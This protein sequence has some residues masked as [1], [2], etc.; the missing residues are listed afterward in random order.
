MALLP[1]P[2]LN[3]NLLQG[4]LGPSQANSG[5]FQGTNQINVNIFTAGTG[6]TPDFSVPPPPLPLQL[7]SW[8]TNSFLQQGF[9]LP[10]QAVQQTR[11]GEVGNFAADQKG[12]ESLL[13]KGFDLRIQFDID[14]NPVRQTWLLKY[15]DFQAS[16]GDP[17]IICPALYKEPLD[18]YNLFNAVLDEGGFHNCNAK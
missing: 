8:A 16:R 13:S 9:N 15:M 12:K 10:P 3:P 14:N 2:I 5:I 7:P 1:P 4:G 18:L 6:G 17:L 11:G